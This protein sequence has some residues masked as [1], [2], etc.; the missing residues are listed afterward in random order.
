ML[1]H[2]GLADARVTANFDIAGGIERG[3]DGGNTFGARERDITDLVA[4]IRKGV[5]RSFAESGACGGVPPIAG[6][7]K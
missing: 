5:A 6:Q 1:Q 2:R 7:A 3:M 4:D